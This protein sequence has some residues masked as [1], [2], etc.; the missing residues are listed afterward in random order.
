MVKSVKRKA[1]TLYML[2]GE[3]MR[4][5][6][7]TEFEYIPALDIYAVVSEDC[8][9]HCTDVALCK[10]GGGGSSTTVQKADPWSGVQPYLKDVFRQAKKL[11]RTS[12]PDFYPGQTYSDLSPQTM[13]GLRGVQ[14]AAASNPIDQYAAL[15]S[16][17]TLGGGY[18]GANPYIDR[19]VDDVTGDIG[20][21]VSSAFAKGGRFGSGAYMGTLAD[22]VGKAAGDIRYQNYAGE[23]ENMQR[24]LA[25]APQVQQMQYVDPMKMLAVGQT[26]EGQTQKGINEA[27]ARHQFYQDRDEQALSQYNALLQGG[28]PFSQTTSQTPTQGSS[29]LA[30]ALGGAMA[31][32]QV[33]GPAGALG[34]A[35]LGGLG[36]F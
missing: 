33:A 10:G 3:H 1:G 27:M 36:L 28:L 11:Y 4:V 6:N 30:G 15:E 14:N 16:A 12:R 17:K 25:L 5:I 26:L 13:A 21:Q 35:V 7:R 9:E 24:A 34:G 18:L 23:R 22:K 20:S 29:P 8:E 19:V 31:G 32:S 2:A